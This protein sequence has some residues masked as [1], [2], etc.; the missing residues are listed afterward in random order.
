MQ[1]STTIK[2]LITAII[3]LIIT[4]LYGAYSIEREKRKSAEL[5]LSQAKSSLQSQT[6]F[7]NEQ[8]DKIKQFNELSVKHAEDMTNAQNE[9][10]DLRVG[11]RDDTKRVYVNADCPAVSTADSTGSV[12][13]AGTAR[14]SQAAR[15]DYL[16]LRQMM[17][18][19]L[20]QTR[21][22]Q[23]Y[24]RTQCLEAK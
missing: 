17:A 10:D 9:I 16:R 8:Q 18:E 23:N 2:I 11:L 6:I 22:L 13:N 5:E 15:N 20:Q 7:I 14:L 4:S 1:L 12:G 24:I 19:N 21:Y 3:A